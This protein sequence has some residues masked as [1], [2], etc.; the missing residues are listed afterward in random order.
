MSTEWNKT[1]SERQ[2]SNFKRLE[3]LLQ[4]NLRK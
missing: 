4:N 3:E 2:D 1:Y